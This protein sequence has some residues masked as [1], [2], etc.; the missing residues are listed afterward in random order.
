MKKTLY[1]LLILGSLSSAL[2]QSRYDNY[3]W[4]QL[5]LPSLSEMQ[6]IASQKYNQYNENQKYLYT[7]K[8]WVRELS[9]Q[10]NI[11]PYSTRL[12][13]EYN[14]LIEIENKDLSRATTYLRQT[15][16]AIKEIIIDYKNYLIN[17]Q[18][19]NEH[20]QSLLSQGIKSYESKNYTSAI[21]SF[22][23]YLEI[24]RTNTDVLFFRALAKTNNN[25]KEG[26]VNDY[27]KI[28]LLNS[29][30]PMLYNDLA[31]VYNNKAYCLVQAKKYNEALPLAEKAVELNQSQAYIWDTRG[32]IY[33]N[34]GY[35]SKSIQDMNKSLSLQ[36]TNNSYY[37]RGL[38]YIQ[39]G[40][41][42]KACNDLNKAKALGKIE[43]EEALRKY[44]N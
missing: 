40:Q 19:N 1:Y 36:E 13:S 16:D 4:G 34:L 10:I 7:L 44:C 6:S 22:S 12:Q 42:D 14:D 11:P 15:E 20:L 17:N 35:Y 3:N 8:D 29:N 5:S 21:N 9:L 31:T 28:I 37:I 43:A 38:A 32:E 27:D 41:K 33:Y 26:A 39:L 25:D 30:Y 2:S 18:K 24:D 23:K